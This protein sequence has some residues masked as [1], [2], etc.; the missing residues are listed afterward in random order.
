MAMAPPGD[1][2]LHQPTSN[3]NPTED[4]P[5]SKKKKSKPKKTTDVESLKAEVEMVN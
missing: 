4:I 2:D 5:T 3:S 1:D